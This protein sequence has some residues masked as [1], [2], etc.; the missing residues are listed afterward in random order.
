MEKPLAAAGGDLGWQGK[1]TNL[2]SRDHGSWLF[3][4]EIYVAV[5]LPPDPPETDR[6]LWHLPSAAFRYLSDQGLSSA[7][8]PTRRYAAA[9][10]T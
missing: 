6:S 10:P 2:V 9:S 7:P 8:V 1:H 5:D 3:L 4:S